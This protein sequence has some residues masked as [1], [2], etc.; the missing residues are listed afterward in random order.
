MFFYHRVHR[1]SQGYI[2][3]LLKRVQSFFTTR[4]SLT[5]AMWLTR[6]T[7][8]TEQTKYSETI[9]FTEANRALQLGIEMYFNPALQDS[10]DWFQR[11]LP[12][13]GRIRV[14]KQIAYPVK[15]CD[16]ACKWLCC[17]KLA[18]RR[19]SESRTSLV[20]RTF[21]VNT[22]NSPFKTIALI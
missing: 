6:G 21:S 18:F 13:V 22:V 16:A 11:N 3:Q 1:V 9:P 12:P 14:K 19:L 15:P 8:Y 4:S 10:T 20:F 7:G 17:G 2:K 5:S